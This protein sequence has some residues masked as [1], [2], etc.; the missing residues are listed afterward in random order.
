MIQLPWTYKPPYGVK[1]NRSHP[2]G[3]SFSAFWAMNEGG[4]D[5]VFDLAG[6]NHLENTGAEYVPGGLYFDGTVRLYLD[7]LVGLW[8]NQLTVLAHLRKPASVSNR[9]FFGIGNTV[10][11]RY[12]N[13]TRLTVTL[14]SV[15]DNHFTTAA[16]AGK[17][18]WL[19]IVIR[20]GG[21]TEL[22]TD[23][24]LE[25]SLSL[26]SR[27][28]GSSLLYIGRNDWGQYYNDNIYSVGI[29][30]RAL[31]GS[32]IRS[33]HANPY[34]IFEPLFI[35]SY[36]EAS[37]STLLPIKLNQLR[38]VKSNSVY[39]RNIQ[40][41]VYRRLL[42]SIPSD[43]ITAA[44]SE[45]FSFSE[46]T[47]NV[48]T[49]VGSATESLNLGDS[50]QR[51][52]N[53]IVN[54]TDS[55]NLTEA[56]LTFSTILSYISESFVITESNSAIGTFGTE[57]TDSLSL[58]ESLSAVLNAQAAVS[59]IVSLLETTSPT[60]QAQATV[61]ETLNLSETVISTI[62]GAIA[63][64]VQ[65]SLTITESNSARADFISTILDNLTLSDNTVNVLTSLHTVEESFTI[66][67]QTFWQGVTQAF[68]SDGIVI[69]E[70]TSSLL[71]MIVQAA[72]SITFT[73]EN[74]VSAIFSVTANDVVQLAEA[75]SNI[76]QLRA[77]I[78]DGINLQATAMEISQLP[79]GKVSVTFSIKTP[80][81][82]FGIK[83]ASLTFNIE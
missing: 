44:I 31:S 36:A 65:E 27:S 75:I 28:L 76:A 1:L 64:L 79:T 3:G 58:S 59:E 22:Y 2:I 19:A 18:V 51:I 4:G 57:I 35:P 12:S 17:D 37:G 82:T 11:I 69:T 5:T 34:Q 30:N 6:V 72:E 49:L 50:G 41:K 83:T 73:D 71:T 68:V 14:P 77:S 7:D 21:T 80:N 78:S 8:Q 81:A 66:S 53:F 45:S 29:V 47:S 70:Q 26:G 13:D 38:Y 16:T 61:T 48:A 52:A 56:A 55:F 32:E 24:V 43:V 33:L 74:N 39:R 25:D 67:D 9:A 54:I 46:N 23:G 42:S 60:L 15:S 20:Q 10:S 63:A 62:E 40:R